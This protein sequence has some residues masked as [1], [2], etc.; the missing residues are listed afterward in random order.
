MPFGMFY[1]LLDFVYRLPTAVQIQLLCTASVERFA[2]ILIGESIQ[3]LMIFFFQ[4]W[5]INNTGQQ[6]LKKQ[7]FFQD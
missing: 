2:N 7:R 1:V 3:Y 4:N 6:K 5:Q